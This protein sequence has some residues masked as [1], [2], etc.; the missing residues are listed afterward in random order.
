MWLKLIEKKNRRFFAFGAFLNNDISTLFRTSKER[1]ACGSN[2][3]ETQVRPA[4]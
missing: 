2:L 1:N 4:G 3:F